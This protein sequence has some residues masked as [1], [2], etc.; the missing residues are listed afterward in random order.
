LGVA[1]AAGGTVLGDPLRVFETHTGHV[2]I[3]AGDGGH[4]GHADE[5]IDQ[6]VRALSLHVKA[7]GLFPEAMHIGLE[8]VA[9]G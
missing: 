1:L 7:A 8:T 9:L 5:G 2:A 4:D 6:I 3:H